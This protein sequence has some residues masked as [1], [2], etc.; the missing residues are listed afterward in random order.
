M[1]Q[2]EFA[3]GQFRTN[4]PRQAAVATGISSWHTTAYRLLIKL[5]YLTDDYIL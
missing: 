2:K 1:T 5:F 4:G 3:L